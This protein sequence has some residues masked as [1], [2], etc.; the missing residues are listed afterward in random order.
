MSWKINQGKSLLIE[1]QEK[2]DEC[3]LKLKDYL[4]ETKNGV[5]II[6]SF[7]E[8][9]LALLTMAELSSDLFIEAEI[10]KLWLDFFSSDLPFY[11]FQSN[12]FDPR[13][14]QGFE[15]STEYVISVRGLV[16]NYNLG[17]TRVYAVR[18]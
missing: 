15:I 16:K 5:K 1:V 13:T 17:Q 2:L 6:K 14:T 11:T 9:K 8:F 3:Q 10:L 12:I 18:G 7:D 4:D